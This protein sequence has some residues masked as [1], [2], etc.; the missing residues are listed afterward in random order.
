MG[1]TFNTGRLI[2]GLFTDASGNVGIG[3]TNPSYKLEIA[4]NT[5]QSIGI[6]STNTATTTN[7]P[8]SSIEFRSYAG[9]Y[10]QYYG[11]PDAIIQS[12]RG[13]RSYNGHQYTH[14]ADLVF[15]TNSNTNGSGATEK[16]RI[17]SDGNVGIGTASPISPLEIVGNTNWSGGWR[18]G[19]TVTS[20]DYPTIRLKAATSGKISWIGNNGDGSL[21]FNVNAT[22]AGSNN[23]AM[24]MS[25]AGNV[26]VGSTA[27]I[28][29]RLQV[30]GANYIEMATFACTTAGASNI[31]SAN[32][33]YVQFSSGS[34]RHCSNT[35]LFVPVTDGIKITKA[36]IVYV[37]VSQ[38]ITTAGS[39]SYVS[40]YIRKNGNTFSENLITN[41]GGQ[42]DG[43][44]AVGTI[45]V[46]ANDVIGFYVSANDIT[47]F[48]PNGWSQYSILW[49]AR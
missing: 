35:A 4:G 9:F 41:T 47:S 16:L 17:T 26:S 3:L 14:D 32:A 40:F 43:L 44:N 48:D 25:P 22:D 2:N 18:Y 31:V 1:K 49:A 45:D 21:Y 36:G 5:S 34:A 39:A 42:W 30:N 24:V 46:A 28:G 12:V 8:Y 19:L 10:N 37:T 38:D 20:N 27:D 33:G 7:T 13:N 11:F 6:S 23:W 15:Y 29:T